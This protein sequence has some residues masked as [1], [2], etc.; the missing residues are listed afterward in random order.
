MKLKKKKKIKFKNN[1]FKKLI[2][3]RKNEKENH[4]THT[5]YK[6]DYTFKHYFIQLRIYICQ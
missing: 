2:L 3:Q 6:T 4:G 1:Y 5:D